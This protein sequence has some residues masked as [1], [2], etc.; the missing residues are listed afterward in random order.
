MKSQLNEQTTE[1]GANRIGRP[2]SIPG[3]VGEHFRSR[4]W[5]GRSASIEST[6]RVPG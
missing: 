5:P 2:L 1:R 6:Q 3:I 4:A